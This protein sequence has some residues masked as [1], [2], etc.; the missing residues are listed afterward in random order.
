[1][2][3]MNIMLI[4]GGVVAGLLVSAL[5]PKKKSDAPKLEEKK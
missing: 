1:M 2:N 3:I 5:L 4:I